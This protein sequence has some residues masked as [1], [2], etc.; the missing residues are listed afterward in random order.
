MADTL[1]D[2]FFEAQA[3][4]ALWDVAVSLKRG[5]ALP[6]DANSVFK[7]MTD[8]DTYRNGGG[9]AYP[10]QVL[11][12]VEEAQTKIYYL[13]QELNVQ[14]VGIIPTGEGAVSVTDAGVIS[15]N[16]DGTTIKIVDGKLAS[17]L[18]GDQKTIEVSAAGAISLIGAAGAANGT[19]PMIEEVQEGETKVSKLVW[20]TLEDIGAG[21][22]N[23]N[24][25]YDFA[26]NAA[27]T[28][29]IV[30]PKFNGQPI[31]SDPE[32]KQN[33][34]VYE[35]DFDDKFV[36]HDELN[37][38]VGAEATE[39]AEATGLYKA[40]ADALADAK[41]YADDNDANDNTTYEIS[42]E[43]AVAGEDGHP[44]RIVLTPSAG[45]PTYVD[46]SMFIA[47]GVLEDVAYNAE[48]KD[49]TFTWNILVKDAEGNDVKKTDVVN[50][51]DLI[52][53]Y[54]AGHGLKLENAEFSVKIDAASEDFLSVGADGLKLAGVQAAIDAAA[55]VADGKYATKTALGELETAL[56]GRLDVL[57]AYDHSTYATKAELTAHGEAADAKYA[58]K[59]ELAP[60]KQTA[61]NAAAKVE[62]LEDKIDE[63]TEVGGEP[64]VIDYIKVNG[65]ILE[66]ERDESGKSTKTVN[67]PVPTAVSQLAN[68]SKFLT[69][70]N[71]AASTDTYTSKL[72]ITG[73][74]GTTRTIDDSALQAA[75]NDVKGT[76]DTAVQT[77]EFAGTAL[78]KTGTKASISKEAAANA[79][80]LG[81]LAYKDDID[82][83]VHAVELQSGSTQGT[84]KLV[85]DS[86]AGADVAVTG[87][88]SAAFANTTDFD[89]DGAAAAVLGLS[90]DNKDAATVYGARALANSILGT[91]ND[92]TEAKTVHGAL[93]AIAALAGEGNTATVKANADAI[94][95]LNDKESVTGSVKN[96]AKTY[97][98]TAVAA[99][100]TPANGDV[101]ADGIL[102]DEIVRIEG[103]VAT[104]KNRAEGVE[105]N[106]EGRIAKMEDFW[107]AV[108]TPDDVIDTLAEIVS[109][110]EK[111]ES[112]AA[113]MA[114]DIKKNSDAL[115]AL[116][117]RV[118][119]NEDKL[120]GINTTVNDA[121]AAAI[122]AAKPGNAGETAGLAITNAV[123]N[124]IE[125]AD[126]KGTVHSLNVNK[127]VQTKNTYLVLNGGN[128]ALTW[129]E[130]KVEE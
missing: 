129:P 88:G 43:S 112:G 27:G 62:T 75:I 13:D 66:V 10:G 21:D 24:T 63:I 20:K 84:L 127:L 102:A 107:K 67:V 78:E 58:T 68:D 19:L 55:E 59:D 35:L 119:A 36:T 31:Y 99:I 61:E 33:Q 94:A 4:A 16:V 40:I 34:I 98:D 105:A 83:G 56:D 122:N 114:A 74:P 38:I 37:V 126:G 17:G 53:T 80:G 76:A 15:V 52:D 97:A 113:A 60:V 51:A 50:I 69:D 87:L 81:A 29:F 65:T 11:A 106:H 92:G 104:E 96:I 45:E 109:Y 108:E 25:T 130:D 64:N 72:K 71:V 79:L 117:P 18:V 116:E 32:T 1:R 90:T 39:T 12:I 8:V 30:T 49:L 48:T 3:S 125:F 95:L 5:N 128:A 101:A 14:P 118:K 120:A 89:A 2:K 41:Q 57:E 26:L 103:L 86:V 110:I 22:G 42:Y 124:G 111:D 91:A 121:I 9:P 70:V 93:A 46:A 73:A 54:T 100:Y 115:A 82:T 77:V 85:V 123:E 47:D 6:L 28:G 44:A 7:S 23:D